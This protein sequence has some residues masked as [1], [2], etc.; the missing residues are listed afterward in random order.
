M[1][2]IK[3]RNITLVLVLA[4]IFSFFAMTNEIDAQDA[5]EQNSG[6]VSL[7]S[8]PDGFAKCGDGRCVPNNC[9]SLNC[10]P[11]TPNGCGN[12]DEVAIT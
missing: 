10:S 2:F 7:S 5:L 3:D 1:K 8:C 9:A 12:K 11:G 6:T 4:I